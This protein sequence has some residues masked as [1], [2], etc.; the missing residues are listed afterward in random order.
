MARPARIRLNA[1]RKI[2]ALSTEGALDRWNPGVKAASEDAASLSIY[3]VIG[4]DPWTG[5]GMTVKRV[6]GIL[7][8]IGNKDVTVNINSPGGDVFEGIAIFNRLREHQGNITV[9]VLGLAA[10]AASIIAMAGDNIQIGASSFLMIHNAWVLA[11]GNKADLREV[12][13]FL[14]PFDRALADVYVA[15]SGQELAAVQAAMDAET[16]FNGS[17]AVELGYA[18][19]LLAADADRADDPRS[20]YRRRREGPA[21]RR[22]SALPRYAEVRRAR[23]RINKIKGKPDAA[24]ERPPSR[25]LATP[26]TDRRSR[27]PSGNHPGLRPASSPRIA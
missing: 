4:E 12:A 7:R 19:E 18:N 15:R 8:A 14:E 16:W 2:T 22:G 27:R 24:L 23:P 17:Q 5:G 26:R 3:E 1:N 6:D 25:T 10:S 20:L 13:D 11:M 9:K 21:P